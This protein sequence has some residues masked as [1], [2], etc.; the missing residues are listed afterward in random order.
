GALAN[1]LLRQSTS[2]VY[3]ASKEFADMYKETVK[4]QPAPAANKPQ[5]LQEIDQHGIAWKP[6][7]DPSLSHLLTQDFF[8]FKK[9]QE[10]LPGE[11]NRLQRVI[12]PHM[13]FILT[14]PHDPTF[15][16]ALIIMQSEFDRA[17]HS[18]S[19][20]PAYKNRNFVLISGLNIDIAPPADDM[21]AYPQTMFLPWASFMQLK[22]GTQRVIEQD[23]LVTMLHKQA[24][25]NPDAIEL[26]KGFSA[27][28]GQEEKIVFHNTRENN[29][30]DQIRTV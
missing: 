23:T 4:T 3:I 6:L 22:D 29:R 15:T 17:V 5:V 30:I 8:K 18:V 27:L 20:A 7:K 12:L 28:F 10:E 21:E 14:A 19:T 24:T 16:A 13:P 11:A 1:P 25:N 9:T 26:E 2:V